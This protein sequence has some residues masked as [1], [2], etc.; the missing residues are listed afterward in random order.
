MGRMGSPFG[1]KMEDKLVKIE[2]F[3]FSVVMD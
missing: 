2:G 3:L 1:D